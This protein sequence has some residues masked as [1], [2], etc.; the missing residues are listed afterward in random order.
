MGLYFMVCFSK[1]LSVSA[2]FLL[3]VSTSSVAQNPPRL[4][5][6]PPLPQA[7]E[8]IDV[9]LL[10]GSEPSGYCIN[11]T[12]N[13]DGQIFDVIQEDNLIIFDVATE[14]VACVPIGPPPIA[15]TFPLAE[16]QAGEYQLRFNTVWQDTTFPASPGDRFFRDEIEFEVFPGALEVP[17]NTTIGLIFLAICVLLFGLFNKRLYR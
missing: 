4:Q 7:G 15:I 10:I 16:L 8:P 2:L 3:L 1:A 12:P 11:P 6:S 14:F 13:I 17:I 5:I 9:V